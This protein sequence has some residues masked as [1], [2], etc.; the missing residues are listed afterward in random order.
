VALGS[1]GV[2]VPYVNDSA[3]IA[4]SQELWLLEGHAGDVMLVT[5]LEG[6]VVSDLGLLRDVLPQINLGIPSGG[7][8]HVG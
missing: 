8:D 3:Q 1:T 6:A 5:V 4:C 7:Q 2:N